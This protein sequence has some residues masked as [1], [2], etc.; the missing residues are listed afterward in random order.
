MAFIQNVAWMDVLRGDH[1]PAGDDATLIQI[2]DPALSPPEPKCTFKEIHKFEFCDVE[3]NGKEPE[4]FE[5]F[6]MK[7]E[8][9]KQIIEILERALEE[10]RN[11]IVHCFA[12][13]CRSGAIAEIAIDMGFKD[14]NTYRERNVWVKK[15]LM[16]ELGWTYE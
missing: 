14:T 16:K 7:P 8:Q 3:D 9:A 2:S 13:L 12:G 11:V 15:L 1:L 5:E 4:M 10:D 6:G